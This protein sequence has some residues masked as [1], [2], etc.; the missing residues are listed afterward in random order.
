MESFS[1]SL[2]GLV[3]EMNYGNLPGRVVRETKRVILDSMAC[4][5]AGHFCD[6]GKFSVDMS[7]RLGGTPECSILGTQEKVSCCSAAFANGEL[8]N[9]LDYDS[10][11]IPP[12]HFPPFVIPPAMA[13]AECLGASGKDLILATA[14]GSEMGSRIAAGLGPRIGSI[15][16]RKSPV[17]YASGQSFFIFGGVISAGKLM[18]LDTEKMTHAMGI[19]GHFCP[20]PNNRK[21]QMTAPSPMTRLTGWVSQAAVSAALLAEMGYLGDTSIFDGEFGFWRMYAYDKWSPDMVLE[22]IG[23]R[24][25]FLNLGYK[26]FPCHRAMHAALDSFL[27]IIESNELRATD[28]ERIKVYCNPSLASQPAS[29]LLTNHVD[30]Q[31][32]IAYIFACAANRIEV[33]KW[34]SR[35]TMEDTEI[36]SYLEKISV[37]APADWDERLREDSRNRWSGGVEIA[38]RGTVF[39]EE[40]RYPRGTA[41]SDVEMTDDELADKFRRSASRILPREKIDRAIKYLLDLEGIPDVRMIME[42]LTL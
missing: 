39:R 3:L 9:A 28:I 19:A 40:H 14:V 25:L 34:Q 4:A 37:E 23:K 6:R 33:E 22:E 12:G 10:F 5:L 42:Q 21:F 24:W 26:R 7:R 30:A 13:I 18:N 29:K 35:E 11:E 32:N 20:V 41:L 2:S 31:S 38:A 8:I 16:G 27:H 36:L 17:L 15:D 1:R